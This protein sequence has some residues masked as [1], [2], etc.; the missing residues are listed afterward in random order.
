MLVLITDYNQSVNSPSALRNR[1]LKYLIPVILISFLFNGPKFFEA[2]V[3]YSNST[4]LATPTNETLTNLT[5]SDGTMNTLLEQESIEW[6]PY[7]SSRYHSRFFDCLAHP[8]ISAT[9]ATDQKMTLKKLSSYLL[10]KFSRVPFTTV[11]INGISTMVNG[12][13]VRDT[14]MTSGSFLI[15]GKSCT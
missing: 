1:L 15:S 13:L 4:V 12:T 7:V 3:G 2:R 6:T 14:K 9:L 11:L 8:N 5:L 10:A